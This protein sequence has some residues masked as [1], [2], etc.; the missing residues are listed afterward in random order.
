MYMYTHTHIY[1][2]IFK[3]YVESLLCSREYSYKITKQNFTPVKLLELKL[4]Y[5]YILTL[6]TGPRAD[7]LK[8][9]WAS[10]LD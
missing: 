3:L 4:K 10:K 7:D 6:L 2:R 1:T 5:I 8:M 9:K